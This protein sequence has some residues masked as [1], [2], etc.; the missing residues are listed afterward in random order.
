MCT[1]LQFL[2]L[3]AKNDRQTAKEQCEYH[4]WD[5][6]RDRD[7][8][9]AGTQ[10]DGGIHEDHV[11]IGTAFRPQI[12]AED[13]FQIFYTPRI[14]HVDP[15]QVVDLHLDDMLCRLLPMNGQYQYEPLRFVR[16]TVQGDDFDRYAGVGALERRCSVQESRMVFRA[17]HVAYPGR[18]IGRTFQ[19]GTVHKLL[20]HLFLN[21]RGS[22]GKENSSDADTSS[23]MKIVSLPCATDT[24]TKNVHNVFTI[25][26]IIAQY[27]QSGCGHITS[28]MFRADHQK[29]T[30]SNMDPMWTHNELD[31]QS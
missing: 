22:M 28:L 15:V 23:V 3:E 17:V 24:A 13:V 4:P 12:V 14:H 10:L 9:A 7:L 6:K 18:Q 31:V 25:P 21:I 16:Q 2:V 8:I 29:S 20:A 1:S 27:G 26:F 19:R 5:G 11:Q 30:E